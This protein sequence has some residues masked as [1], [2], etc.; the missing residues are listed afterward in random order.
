[1]GLS[2]AEDCE[3]WTRLAYEATKVLLDTSKERHKRQQGL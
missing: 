1:M 3:D 2:I